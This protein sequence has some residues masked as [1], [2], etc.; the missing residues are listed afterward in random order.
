MHRRHLIA[1]TGAGLLAAPA[2]AH[3]Q[4]AW[5]GRGSI[6]MVVGFPPGGFSDFVARLLT[7]PM[8]A[9]IGQTMIVENRPGAGGTV[10]ADNV[11]KSPPDGYSLFV[12]HVS[13]HGTAPGVYPQLPYNVITDF[14]HLGMI[15]DTPTA[16]MVRRDSPLRSMA[17]LVTAMRGPGVRYGTSGVGSIGHLQ[18]EL[19][20]RMAGAT[21]FEHVPYRGTAPALQDL[22]AGTIETVFD[23]LAGQMT[24]VTG[25]GPMRLL[26][27]SAPARL[28]ALP[29]VPTLAEAGFADATATAWMGLSGPRGLPAPIAQ[30]L[31]EALNAAL[32]RPDTL[33]RMEELTV[34][35]PATPLNGEAFAGF[36][37]DF[38]TK[39]MAVA[40][41]A[42]IVAT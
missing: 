16:I 35:P 39:W 30:R 12:T 29:D 6:R 11:A 3:A 2:L 9:T 38:S 40:R 22:L 17:D 15:C 24:Q 4:A 25:N 31:T 7:A 42:N 27:V 34:F 19:V 21:R 10:G 26:C 23:P 13:P 33:A 32:A 1:A 5:P 20:M 14:T 8:G 37:R 41:A 36:I 28:A 18:G